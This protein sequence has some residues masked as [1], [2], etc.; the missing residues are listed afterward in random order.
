MEFEWAVIWQKFSLMVTEGCLFYCLCIY[1][2]MSNLSE[3]EKRRLENIRANEA[4][5]RGLD[6]P[7]PSIIKEDEKRAS[8]KH[9]PK[10]APKQPQVGIR[11]SARIRGEKPD[12]Q[13]FEHK[14]ERIGLAPKKVK[15]EYAISR[16]DQQKLMGVLGDTLKA[17]NSVPSANKET[18]PKE[19]KSY[20]SLKKSLQRLEIRHEW[21]TVKVA[22]SRIS[23]CLFHPSQTKILACAADT[24]GYIG[25]W[26]VNGQEADGD[27]VT[28]N[29][30]PHKRTVSDMHFNPVDTSKLLSSSYDGTIQVFDMNTGKFDALKTGDDY[31]F[32]GFDMTQ[33]GHCIW[34]TTSDGELGFID[35]R[36]RKNAIVHKVKDKKVGCVH[37]NPVHSHLM[38]LASNDRTNTIW[39]VRM[40][41]K[42]KAMEPLQSIEH[43][44]SVTSSYWSPNGDILAT[45]AYDNFV[46]LFN[47]NENKTL[48]L[49]TAIK[50]NCTTGRWVTN[51]RARWNT[52]K[53]QGLDNQHLVVGNMNHT[54]DLISGET[55]EELAS[56]YDSD[57]ITAIP[58]VAQFHPST[59]TPVILIGNG[60]GR[61]VCWS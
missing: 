54:L 36:T 49:K 51:L 32:T 23:T 39:D 18:R 53:A 7:T 52:N 11:A 16:E 17:P 50:H 60:S 2:P 30:K 14:R 21:D 3:Y 29:H 27:P 55:G 59:P 61:M 6:L 12:L 34:F 41:N 40:W 24:E 44:Y 48:E 1:L 56:L 13:V 58:S 20:Q 33:D 46:R 43:G 31:S 38:T 10:A 35:T 4:L 8:R 19:I 26:D 9:V 57:H 45:T 42:S 47:L 15:Y 28:Y 37:L 5:L 25:F 22:S